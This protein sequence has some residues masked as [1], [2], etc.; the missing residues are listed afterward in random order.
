M[1]HFLQLHLLT[2]YPPSNLNRDDTGRPKT[3]TVGGVPRLRINSQ[4]L[5]RAWRTSSVFAE[6]LHEHLG[7]RTQRFG[8]YIE[9]HLRTRGVPED[10]ALEIARS[11]AKHFGKLKP[12][13]DAAPARTEQLAFIA[14]EESAAALTLADRIAAGEKVSNRR[15]NNCYD[16]LIPPPTSQC[17]GACS[18]I[19][20][21]ITGR[22]RCRWHTR[23]RHIA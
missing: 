13:R 16:I 18:Q 19:I 1:S 8:E 21:N 5:K 2:F 3:A 17:S 4:A 11:I 10:R 23:L 9:A 12:E 14:P 22:P 20:H 15:P 6:R 7:R